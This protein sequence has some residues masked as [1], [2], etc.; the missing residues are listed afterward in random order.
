MCIILN[1]VYEKDFPL[2]KYKALWSNNYLIALFYEHVNP[3]QI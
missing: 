3:C 1:F 2:K